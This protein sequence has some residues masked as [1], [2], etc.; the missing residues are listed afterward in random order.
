VI[1]PG[2]EVG[3]EQIWIAGTSMGGFGAVVC[4]REYSEAVTGMLLLSPYLGPEKLL[5]RI[6][7]SG[8]LAQ[9]TPP[10]DADDMEMIWS[11]LQGY[12]RGEPR[13]QIL[14]AFGERDRLNRGHELLSSVLQEDRVLRVDGGHGWRVWDSLWPEVLEAGFNRKED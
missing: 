12:S 5:R 14:L 9:W 4:S 8:G 10:D 1:Q 11:W 6:E 3:Y 7:E 2:Q 13:P